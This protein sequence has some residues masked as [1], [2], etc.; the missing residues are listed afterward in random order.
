M[1]R[2][3]DDAQQVFETAC[4]A[5]RDGQSPDL[6]VIVGDSGAIRIVL[7]EGWSAEGLR[8]EYG[9]AAYRVKLSGNGVAVDGCGTGLSCK[10]RKPQPGYCAPR[11]SSM[12]LRVWKMM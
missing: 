4:N 7:A 12:A 9:G 5:P 8:S 10:L 11:D 1:S 6:A 2:F 3:W